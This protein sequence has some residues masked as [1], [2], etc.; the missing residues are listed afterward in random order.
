MGEANNFIK[1][2]LHYKWKELRDSNKM[3]L[4]E[5]GNEVFCLRSK[6]WG[7]GRIEVGRGELKI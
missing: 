3:F 2:I 5:A 4:C 6:R 7:S 1:L